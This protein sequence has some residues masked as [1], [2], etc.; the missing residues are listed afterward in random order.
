MVH[1]EAMRSV[2][3][4]PTLDAAFKELVLTLPSEGYIAEQ[5]DVVDPQ[6][7]HAVREAM[8]RQLANA[9]QADWAW[10]YEQHHE[11]GA[12]TPDPVSS[13]KRSLAGMALQMLCL[14]ARQNADTVWPGKAYQRVKDAGNMTDRLNALQALELVPVAERQLILS[15]NI[16]S[17]QG[18]LTLSDSGPGIHPELLGRIFEPFFSTR[19]RGLGLGLS[20][21]ETL[22]MGMGGTLVASHHTPRGASFHLALPL[23]TASTSTTPCL[24]W[25]I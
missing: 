12:Y 5:L 13:G 20:L 23:A 6:R 16:T 3:R 24:P 25:S 22:A 7:I 17:G 2:L 8:R 10:A 18:V 4:H 21:C 1:I 14:A 11:T 9:L 15:L 19:E